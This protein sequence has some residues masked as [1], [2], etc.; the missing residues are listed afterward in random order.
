MTGPRSRLGFVPLA[1]ERWGDV[2]RADEA[3]SSRFG[4]TMG[5]RGVRTDE[6]ERAAL[7]FARA[8]SLVMASG[9]S[10][11]TLLRGAA[12]GVFRTAVGSSLLRM[13][14]VSREGEVERSADGAVPPALRVVFAPACGAASALPPASRRAS[15]VCARGESGFTAAV[16]VSR[17]DAV[18][19]S[20]ETARSGCSTR[21]GETPRL[22]S[23]CA[24]TLPSP[25]GALPL[26][27]ASRL[28]RVSRMRFCSIC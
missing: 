18:P 23:L 4:L 8:A 6:S 10:W 13:G 1:E 5:A 3:L 12:S 11:I 28:G 21:C 17:P 14:L 20:A 24:A 16:R 19:R 27:A 25:A 7:V 26:G 2:V 22:E 15:P 9:R